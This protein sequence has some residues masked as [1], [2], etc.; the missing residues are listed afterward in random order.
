MKSYC[1]NHRSPL[2]SQIKKKLKHGGRERTRE[3]KPF[4]ERSEV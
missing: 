3:K 1:S 4:K 2:I